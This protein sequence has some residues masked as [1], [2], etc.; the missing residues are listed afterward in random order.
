MKSWFAKD[1]LNKY[2]AR[3]TNKKIPHTNKIINER[4]DST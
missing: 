3:L 2:L 1:K 4:E